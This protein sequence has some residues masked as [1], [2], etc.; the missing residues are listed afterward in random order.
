VGESAI[1]TAADCLRTKYLA[2]VAASLP[3]WLTEAGS[4][5]LTGVSSSAGKPE[6][7]GAGISDGGARYTS[8]ISG[9]SAFRYALSIGTHN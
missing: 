1:G 9:V 3:M 4:T 6:P 5:F 8:G 2:L 7:G